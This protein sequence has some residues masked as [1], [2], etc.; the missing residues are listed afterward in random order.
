MPSPAQH[1]PASISIGSYEHQP[2]TS[3]SSTLQ[4]RTTTRLFFCPRLFFLPLALLTLA[5][6][7]SPSLSIIQSL[8][9]AKKVRHHTLGLFFLPCKSTTRKL[10]FFLTSSIFFFKPSGYYPRLPPPQVTYYYRDSPPFRPNY[11]FYPSRS[12]TN[13]PIDNQTYYYYYYSVPLRLSHFLSAIAICFFKET[14]FT[15]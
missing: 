15:L 12:T 14:F 11:L 6:F 7:F 3:A 4:R 5:F 13:F 2:S 9:R 8:A 1:Q 10:P